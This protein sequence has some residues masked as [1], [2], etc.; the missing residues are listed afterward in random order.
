MR[1][2]FKWLVKGLDDD[3]PDRQQIL[4]DYLIDYFKRSSCVNLL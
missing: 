1:G 4:T 2:M 3:I